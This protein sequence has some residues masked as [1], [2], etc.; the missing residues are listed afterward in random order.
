MNLENK[1]ITEIFEYLEEIED[2]I[3][4]INMRETE[5]KYY[6][7]CEI[8][9]DLKNDLWGDFYL[10][11]ENIS[12]IKC[13]LCWFGEEDIKPIYFENVEFSFIILTAKLFINYIKN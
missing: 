1:K 12:N 2:S 3:N 6:P 7:L 11:K 8:I 13:S 4:V 9:V 5:H 10:C